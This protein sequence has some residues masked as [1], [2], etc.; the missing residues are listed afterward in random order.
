LT[1]N[2]TAPGP[3]T[4][5]EH[6]LRARTVALGKESLWVALDGRVKL[7]HS[8]YPGRDERL[9]ES[10]FKGYLRVDRSTREV[11]WLRLATQHGKYGQEPFG[12]AVRS[13]P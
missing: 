3:D 12:V 4:L 9:A 2:F 11:R 13:L 8:F 5:L 10:D 7:R 6:S 1:G